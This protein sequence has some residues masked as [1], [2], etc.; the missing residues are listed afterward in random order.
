MVTT[1]EEA[2]E[3]GDSS[4][5]SESEN[6]NTDEE[7]K[8]PVFTGDGQGVNKLHSNNQLTA[9]Q[10]RRNKESDHGLKQ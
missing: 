10:K 2:D 4:S 1:H 9:S 7:E 3:N 6:A 8:T 5:R